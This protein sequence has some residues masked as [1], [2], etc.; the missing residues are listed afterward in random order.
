MDRSVVVAAECR[1]P[2]KTI[3]PT[4]HKNG[5]KS[6]NVKPYIRYTG[7]R[8]KIRSATSNVC[9][10]ISGLRSEQMR[11]INSIGFGSILNFNVDIIPT[12]LGFWL[13]RNYDPETCTLNVG[14]HTI[15]I[16]RELVH[17][18]FGVPMGELEIEETQRPRTADAVVGEWNAQFENGEGVRM[19]PC[20]LQKRI[21]R[22]TSCGRH[23][24]LNFLIFINTFLGETTQNNTI[25]RFFL[26]SI[27]RG[28]DIA[29]FDWCTYMITT[30]NRCTTLWRDTKK[31]FHGSVALL[32]VRYYIVSINLITIRILFFDAIKN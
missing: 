8:L 17:N 10:M 4:E 26:P 5:T 32:A 20:N 22:M 11:A 27:K 7:E 16:T 9:K 30:L 2:L 6:S 28:V 13:L 19:S 24:I 12:G 15:S 1:T 14:S 31:P 18:I 21:E 3:T 23:F 25:N 29:S